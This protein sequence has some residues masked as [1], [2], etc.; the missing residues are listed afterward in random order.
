[1]LEKY[2]GKVIEGED[3]TATE[4]E[5]AMQAIMGGDAENIQTAAFLAALRMKGET[6]EEIA[7]FAKVM[8]SM[9]LRIHPK[10]AKSVD[11]CGTGGDTIKTFNISTTAAFIA[12]CVVPVAKHGNRSVTSKCGSADV[13]EELGANLALSPDKITES[14]EKIGIG[15]M[16]APVHHQAMKNVIEVRQKL[17]MRTVFNVLG[18]LTNPANATHQLIGVYDPAL[19]EK[20][21]KVLRILGLKKALVVHGEPGL[22]E[23][24]ISGKTKISQLEKGEITTYFIKPDDFG[25]DVAS[26]EEIAG[27]TREESA[28]ILRDILSCKEEGAKRDVVLLNAASAIFAADEV[29]SI[30]E[31][32]VIARELLESRQ[33]AKKLEEF[34]TFAK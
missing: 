25:M 12:A 22:D 7:A 1:M 14:I 6:E 19:T 13:I 24:S 11:V 28:R 21:A 4:A 17:G 32:V 3:L 29:E 16:F 27:S 34:L 8:R 20:I 18:P 26:P 33:A 2:L 10:V 31:G 5:A 23:V 30:E 15:F 9:A